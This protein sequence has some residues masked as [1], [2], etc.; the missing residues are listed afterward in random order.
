LNSIETSPESWLDKDF[1]KVEKLQSISLVSTNAA[2]SWKLTRETEIAPWV[3]ADTRAGEVL[4][5]NK[6]SSLAASALSY[7]SFV[8]VASNTAPAVTGLDKPLALTLATFDHFTYDLKIGG[9]TPEG[10][11]YLTVAAAARHSRPAD[12]RRG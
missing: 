3:L 12:R 2:D 6:V 4:D 11:F 9:K 7:A 10:N 8:D 5:S 1:Y